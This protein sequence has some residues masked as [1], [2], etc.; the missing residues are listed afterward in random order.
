V[1]GKIL[2]ETTA[3]LLQAVQTFTD[4]YGKERKAGEQWLVTHELA[5]CHILDVHEIFVEQVDITIIKEDEFC[6]V[7]N[8]VDEHGFNQL[9]KKVLVTGPKSFFL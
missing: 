5:S 3:L 1:K 6:Y 9:G 8:P 2:N 4:V 7:L